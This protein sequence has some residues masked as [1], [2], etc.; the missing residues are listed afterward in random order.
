MNLAQ[1]FDSNMAYQLGHNVAVLLNT[2]LTVAFEH[3][4]YHCATLNTAYWFN[5]DV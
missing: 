2:N 5:C 1:A 3:Q 4:C